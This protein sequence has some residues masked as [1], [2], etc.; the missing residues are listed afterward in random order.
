MY[1]N[2]RFPSAAEVAGYGYKAM[3]AGK[4]VA[5]HGVLNRALAFLVRL[6]P[7]GLVMRIAGDLLK[8]D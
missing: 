4:G 1:R 3:L 6:M 2:L 5:V 7:A 8:R